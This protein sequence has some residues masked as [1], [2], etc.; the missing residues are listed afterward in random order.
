M[1]LWAAAVSLRNT[2]HGYENAHEGW[3][4]KDNFKGKT[5]L[6]NCLEKRFQDIEELN[7]ELIAAG[8]EYVSDAV[9][10]YGLA[11]VRKKLK[12]SSFNDN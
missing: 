7:K 8:S 2:Y 12:D 5:K 3:S 1:D 11:Q 4:C 6:I 9:A 10:V